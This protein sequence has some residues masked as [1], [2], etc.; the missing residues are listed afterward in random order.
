MLNKIKKQIKKF[1]EEVKDYL[2]TV[3]GCF[4]I[5]WNENYEEES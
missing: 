4:I 2:Y 3:K 5:G 1:I